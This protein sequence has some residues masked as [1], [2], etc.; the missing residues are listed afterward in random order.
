MRKQIPP[1]SQGAHRLA[2]DQRVPQSKVHKMRWDIQLTR[3]THVQNSTA[4]DIVYSERRGFEER[5][6]D[7]IFFLHFGGTMRE[8]DCAKGSIYH[9]S[10]SFAC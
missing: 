7:S 5:I 6:N 8:V 4:G 3:T 9:R 10:D 1:P 2:T